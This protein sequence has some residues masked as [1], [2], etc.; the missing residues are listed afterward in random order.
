[1]QKEKFGLNANQLKIIAAALML[2]D[3]IGYFLFPSNMFLRKMGSL[4]LIEKWILNFTTL[5][6]VRNTESR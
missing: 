5:T 2:I 1:M 4:I 6:K 3:H